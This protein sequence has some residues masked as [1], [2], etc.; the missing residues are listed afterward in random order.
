MKINNYVPGHSVDCVIIGFEN[1]TL[2]VLVLKWKGTDFWTLPGG[3]VD[4]DKDIDE[5]AK[6][7]VANENRIKTSIFRTVS[8]FRKSE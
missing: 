3:F 7:C 8:Y 4:R 1:G 6:K 2:K 5:S